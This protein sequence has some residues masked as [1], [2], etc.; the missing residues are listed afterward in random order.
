MLSLEE[1]GNTK[2][3]RRKEDEDDDNCSVD[4]TKKNDS[5]NSQDFNGYEKGMG[6]N[7]VIT[8]NPIV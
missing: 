2:N 1:T 5:K 6:N 7:W 4:K 3:D 8:L